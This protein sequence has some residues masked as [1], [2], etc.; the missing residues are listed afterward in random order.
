MA[1]N[2]YKPQVLLG[3]DSHSMTW[4]PALSIYRVN[5]Y[6]KQFTLEDKLAKW[7][8]EDSK[9][10]FIE[11]LLMR[12]MDHCAE[13]IV[14]YL[15]FEDQLHSLLVSQLWNQFIAGPVFRKKLEGLLG[16]EQGL[17]ELAEQEGWSREEMEG[18]EAVNK[19]LL[20]KV[21]LLKDIWRTRE[22]KARRLF[23]DSFVLSV[24]ADEE[25]ILCGLN[26][27]CVQ[28]WDIATLARVKEQECHEKGVKCIDMNTNVFLTGSYDTTFKVWR[29]S[30][31]ELLQTFPL[32]TD[33]VWDLRLHNTTVATA[34]LDGAVILF[35]FKTEFE[36]KVRSY[37]QAHGDLVSAVDF[38][39][40]HLVT[41]HE[42]SYV[43]VWELPGGRQL[44][45]MLGHNGGVTGITLQG[46]L[47]A[48]S[49]YDCE[50]RLW[51]VVLGQCLHIFNEPQN[52]V[53]CLA[54][55][56][57]RIVSGDFGGFVHMWDFT[58][59]DGKVNVSTHRE[60]ECHKGHVVC[61]QLSASRIITG[62]RDRNVIVN[63]FWA[64]TQDAMSRRAE[65]PAKPE[66]QSRFLK[67]RYHY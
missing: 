17:E 58:L 53:R 43:G 57:K 2:K 16:K 48:T 56:G 66:R 15:N 49:S 12:N 60:W 62:S 34:G 44:H 47:A 45:Q 26:N 65:N 59:L 19:K 33:S 54:F 18:E 35:D 21:F 40:S 20:A 3:S 67:S 46:S 9:L 7:K 27:G 64:K 55:H 8:Y 1:R 14:S 31:W 38:S 30:S 36:V 28:A 41:G 10:D 5:R 63:D 32:H 61:I 37:I 42:D 51:D 25:T 52:F 39:D 6:Q 50:V 22:P 13:H 23:C 24:R 4:N 11:E 29:R